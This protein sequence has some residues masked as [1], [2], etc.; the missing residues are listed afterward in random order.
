MLIQAL[1]STVYFLPLPAVN[2]PSAIN[3]MASAHA[4][5]DMGAMIA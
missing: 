4:L 5:L 2:I 1:V 3:T